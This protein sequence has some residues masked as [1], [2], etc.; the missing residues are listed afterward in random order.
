MS[1]LRIVR[2]NSSVSSFLARSNSASSLSR[3]FLANSGLFM[4]EAS[5]SACP[6]LISPAWSAS[7][8]LGSFARP[9]AVLVALLASRADMPPESRSRPTASLRRRASS[10]TT[11]DRRGR[12]HRV[13]AGQGDDFVVQRRHVHPGHRCCGRQSP[14]ETEVV[15]CHVV[16]LPPVCDDNTHCRRTHVRWSS[17]LLEGSRWLVLFG[18]I[19]V[20]VVW[21]GRLSQRLGGPVLWVRGV[22]GVLGRVSGFPPG[23]LACG[24]PS[25]RC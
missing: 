19:W 6:G 1:S 8:V 2:A 18:V 12:H 24:D 5:C 3:T 11:D 17:G 10:A 9:S 23:F 15:C 4:R 25:G 16:H 20:L 7:R 14:A 22:V 21:W 13:E